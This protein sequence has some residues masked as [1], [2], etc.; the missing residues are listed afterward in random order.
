M[1]QSTE[2]VAFVGAADLARAQV[3]YERALGLPLVE[4]NDFA[5]VFRLRLPSAA[6][7]EE[8]PIG[9]AGLGGLA[10][11]GWHAGIAAMM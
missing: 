2:V 1:L 11:G 10:H 3:F 8:R 9:S 5:C 7:P 4:H 6:G